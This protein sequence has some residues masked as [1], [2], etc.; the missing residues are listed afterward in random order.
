MLRKI[1][2][3]LAE[4][5][6]P[7]KDNT[8]YWILK[9]LQ[10]EKYLLEI[11]DIKKKY[12]IRK[13]KKLATDILL[14]EL[15]NHIL[16]KIQTAEINHMAKSVTHVK[17]FSYSRCVIHVIDSLREKVKDISNYN[18]SEEEEFNKQDII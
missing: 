13:I 8:D 10:K 1:R 14:N 9:S 3:K 12:G 6:H 7:E 11:G 17:D 18:I 15:W 4:F 5:I 16:D 2:I